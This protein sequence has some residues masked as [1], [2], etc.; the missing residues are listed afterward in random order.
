MIS[1]GQ[2]PNALVTTPAALSLS[3]GG[4]AELE[5]TPPI[6]AIARLTSFWIAAGVAFI[7]LW[8]SL[9]PLQS[10]VIA[11]AVVV[12]EG[13]RKPVQSQ[14][15]G[16]IRT[17]FVKEGATVRAGDVLVEFDR[18]QTAVQYDVY[19]KQL[20][21]AQV[22]AAR[23]HSEV[24]GLGVIALPPEIVARQA[25]DVVSDLMAIERSLFD[26][27]R[28]EYQ[29]RRDIIERKIAEL[30]EQLSSY[31]SSVTSVVQQIE[32]IEE[33][34]KT[35]EDLLKK[36]LERKP[37]LLALQRTSAALLG[38]RGRLLADQRRIRESIASSELEFTNLEYDRL[39]KTI[40]E[41]TNVEAQINELAERRKSA[42]QLLDNTTISAGEDGFVVGLQ[43]FGPGAV[44]APGQPIL[45]I[46]PRRDAKVL[47]AQIRPS[48][49]DAVH[50]G[51]EAEAR[52]LAYDMRKVEP[53]DAE[54]LTVSADRL[55]DKTN[56]QSYF[57]ARIRVSDEALSRQPD[58]EL[59]PG[60]PADVIIKTGE[61]TVFEYLMKPFSRF[62]FTSFREE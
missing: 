8:C 11:S 27:R 56:N 45:D 32:L 12:V 39:S 20:L 1:T 24:K 38:E 48:D 46:V 22:R 30:K 44:V 21:K 37:R 4:T 28:H 53:L 58:I 35:V 60:M 19:D 9:I 23:L 54:V 14:T 57:E 17:L 3:I 6:G 25:E 40:D 51:L 31:D 50:V 33:E 43:F 52:L 59:Y 26:A 49:I 5:A 62:L 10:A 2:Q 16:T 61:R 18:V 41:L 34:Q 29:G 36:G 13:N 47:V 55:I 42:R 15:G 7:M